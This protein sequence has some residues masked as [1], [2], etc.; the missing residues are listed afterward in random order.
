MKI[1]EK[2]KIA[3]LAI[4]KKDGLDPETALNNMLQTQLSLQY[5]GEPERKIYFG[6][7]V[8]ASFNKLSQ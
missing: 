4:A 6:L 8:L 1:N 2:N 7:C 5:L 3:I